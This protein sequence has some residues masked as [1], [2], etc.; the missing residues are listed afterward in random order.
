MANQTQ[1]GL[2]KISMI[3]SIYNYGTCS[4]NLGVNDSVNPINKKKSI[5]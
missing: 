4:R 1:K 5:N 2:N 3:I